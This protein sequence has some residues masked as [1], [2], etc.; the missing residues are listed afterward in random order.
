MSGS[1]YFQFRKIST[2]EAVAKVG[3][4]SFCLCLRCPAA[5]AVLG[6]GLGVRRGVYRLRARLILAEEA[7]A[8]H[9]DCLGRSVAQL[10][11]YASLR[12]AD[13]LAQQEVECSDWLHFPHVW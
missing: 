2:A 9:L 8:D 5:V 7:E 3:P 1:S 10:C 12:V 6:P 11:D 4:C 13:F